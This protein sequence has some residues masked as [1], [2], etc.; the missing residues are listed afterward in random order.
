[1][2]M[3]LIVLLGAIGIVNGLWSKNLVINGTVTT[4]DLNADWDCGW[5]NDDGQTLVIQGGGCDTSITEPAGDTGEDPNNYDW[6]D[7][8]DYSPFEP[9]DVG[10]CELEIGG[11]GDLERFGDQVAYVTI[12]NAYPSYECTITLYITNTGSIPFNVISATLVLGPGAAGVI[13]TEACDP[14]DPDCEDLI[15]LCDPNQF[16]LDEQGVLDPQIDPGEERA[17]ECTVHVT[18]EAEQSDC[19]G[20]TTEEGFV[21]VDET[22]AD[23]P[24]TYVFAID[25]CVAQWNEDAD[26]EECK[27]SDQHEGPPA[28]SFE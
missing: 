28:S 20:V 22:C 17:F 23:P 24:T 8:T 16:F 7:F 18:Q 10:E 4:G 3:G 2:F 6:P 21:S 9:K 19:T 15:D 11:V 12:S 1:M 13:E 25:V 26:A 27:T 5:T 14:A